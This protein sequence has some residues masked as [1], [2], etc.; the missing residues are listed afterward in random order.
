MKTLML[1]I[2]LLVARSA[3]GWAEGSKVDFDNGALLYYDA[4]CDGPHECTFAVIGCE[5]ETLS[6]SFSLDQ[7]DISAWFTK[8]NGRVLLK[9]GQVSIETLT[10]EIVWGGD[11]DDD[12]WPSLLT[13]NESDTLWALLRPNQTL[14]VMAGP[15]QLNLII[16][17]EIDD[18]RASCTR[19]ENAE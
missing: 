17:K 4:A 19:S 16:P 18:V 11:M 2:A 5:D 10:S 12:W 15:K 9:V 13:G 6:I 8:S 1:A 3:V 7:K 14:E